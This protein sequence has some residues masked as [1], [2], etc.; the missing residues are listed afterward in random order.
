VTSKKGIIITD[1]L[2]PKVGPS[3]WE[4]IS[5]SLNSN[6]FE[7]IFCKNVLEAQKIILESYNEI[8]FLYLTNPISN[9]KKTTYKFITFLKKNDKYKHIEIFIRFP[10]EQEVDKSKWYDDFINEIK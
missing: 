4:S 9:I 10:K 8:Y 5:S 3:E 1:D 6:E 7:K 2:T